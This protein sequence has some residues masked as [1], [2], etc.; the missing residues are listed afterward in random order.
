MNRAE[1]E[2]LEERFAGHG[3]IAAASAAEADIIV[4]NSCVVRKHAEDKVVN[5]LSNLKPLKQSKPSLRIALTGC[6]VG[7]DSSELRK[8]FPYVDD[9]LKPGEIPSWLEECSPVLPVKSGV[10]A[11]V[12][13][14]QGC[15]NFCSYCIVP[16]RRGREVS[17]PISEIIDEVKS[18]VSR[19]TKEVTLVGQNV[20]SYGHDLEGKPDLA[21]LLTR[22]N[23]VPGLLRI[24]FLTNHPKDM[25]PRLIDAMAKLSKICRQINLPVQAGDDT[26]LARMKRGYTVAEYRALMGRLRAAMPD[27][28]VT[29][30]V[31]VGFPGETDEQFRN[32][33]NLLAELKF[34]AIHSA[35]YSIRPGTYAAS[36]YEDDV[37][38]EV[39]KARLAAVEAL[40]ENISTEI[41]ARLLGQTVEVLVETR[42]K[43]RW[44]GR[45]RADKLV[46]FSGGTDLE[47]KEVGVLIEKTSAWSMQ[48][49]IIG[50]TQKPP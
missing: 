43:G 13:I 47:G 41:N 38:A 6:L 37:P 36:K 17:R 44:Q 8:R 7:Q 33:Y 50:D 26:V 4:V 10:T 40:E 30:D 11:Y 22:L 21:D 34:E 28:T 35:A 14:I 24:R 31:I 12:P 29:T 49:K 3:Y 46:F 20:D 15:N 48:G 25:S 18:L 9:F 5:K 16:Y 27:I 19:G 42:D 39:K 23:E 1:S 32:T 2:R 45:T